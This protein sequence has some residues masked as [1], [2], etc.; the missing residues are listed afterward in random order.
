MQKLRHF[1]TF[2]ILLVLLGTT[3]SAQPG[4]PVRLTKNQGD[5]IGAYLIRDTIFGPVLSPEGPGNKIEIQGYELGN[6][7]FFEQE[8]NTVWYKLKAHYTGEMAFDIIPLNAGDDFDF[9]L[10]EDPSPA[11]CD[12]VK[13]GEKTP[14][15]TNISRASDQ[16]GG[17]TGLSFDS[18][19][20]YVPAG[21]GNPYSRAVKVKKGDEFIL[22]I[23]NPFKKNE[24]HSIH[25]HY[26]RKKKDVYVRPDQPDAEL[27]P[28]DVDIKVIDTKSGIPIKADITILGSGDPQSITG[29]SAYTMKGEVY[30][31]YTIRAEKAGYM[32]AT[33][34]ITVFKKDNKTVEIKLQKIEPGVKVTLSNIKFAADKADIL[35]TSKK[36]L[37]ALLSFMQKNPA[38]RIEIEGHVNA[39]NA[40]NKG[41]YKKLSKQRAAA[42]YHN[43]ILSGI[44][45]D[46][47]TYV[48]YGNARMIY[49]DPRADHQAEANR[50]VE[51]RILSN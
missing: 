50:R 30:R 41:K 16:V 36:D 17:R 15:R 11:F 14:V 35:P 13:L 25:I 40:K 26:K 33:K 51:I 38:V 1:Q 24:G 8:H 18:D 28:A 46:R 4:K 22:V 21:P 7:Y 32:F 34:R 49:P 42:I 29:V 12:K 20:D 31:S 9:L 3:A 47:M 5:C 37:D 39:P 2:F 45:K 6:E 10:F 23:D 44:A 27:E 48:G 19:V 43:L